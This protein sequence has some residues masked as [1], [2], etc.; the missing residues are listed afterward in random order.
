MKKTALFAPMALLLALATGCTASA[1]GSSTAET[2]GLAPAGSPSSNTT[3]GIAGS[4]DSSQY[5]AQTDAENIALADAGL[6]ADTLSGSY[7]RL[8][9]DDGR[10]VYDV[11]FWTAD[12]EYDYE[13]DAVTGEILSMDYDADNLSAQSTA[14]SGTVIGEDAARL[15]ALTHAGLAERSDIQF[16]QCKLDRDD[17]QTLYEVEFHVGRTE[18]SYEIDAYTGAILKSEQEV[19]D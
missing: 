19:D 1:M 5:I 11:E 18:Y 16:L 7:T 13:I 4:A 3:A 2:S 8:E 9:Y 14:A 15:A 12:K 10:A 6:T 17:G